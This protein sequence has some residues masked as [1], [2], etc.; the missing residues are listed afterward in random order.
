MYNKSRKDLGI[1]SWI[2]GGVGEF[3]GPAD[4][5]LECIGVKVTSERG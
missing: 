3:L 5:E 4:E 1:R 2:F